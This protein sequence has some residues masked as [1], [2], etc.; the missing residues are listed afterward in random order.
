MAGKPTKYSIDPVEEL[1]L[2]IRGQKV[3]LDADISRIYGVPTKRLNEQIKR[4]QDRFPLDFAFRLTAQEKA[5]VVANCDHLQGLRFS[6]V[7]PLA[8]T[9]H[10]ALMAANVLN[11]PRAVEMSVFVIRAFVKMREKL[12][13]NQVLEKRL[14][15]IEKK[16]L[17][18]DSS[19][20]D[21]YDRI[22]P[23]LL[24]PPEKPKRR[25]GYTAEEKRVLY[26]VR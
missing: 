2:T 1:I 22:R 3:I 21:L 6:P 12:V 9:E 11:S 7:L 24:P 23:L 14:A 19:L 20:R 5:E 10:G 15:E 25:I 4:N 26:R 17:L 8:F 16:L 18:H 13:A